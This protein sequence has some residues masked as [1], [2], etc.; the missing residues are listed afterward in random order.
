MFIDMGE[1]TK[2]NPTF[3]RGGAKKH[4]TLSLLAI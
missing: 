1:V 4:L 2:S 3:K